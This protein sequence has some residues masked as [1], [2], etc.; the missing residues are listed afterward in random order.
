M[1]D[2]LLSL[3]HDLIQPFHRHHSKIF[4]AMG[5]QTGRPAPRKLPDRKLCVLVVPN[6]NSAYGCMIC[7]EVK[8]GD[9]IL[10]I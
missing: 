3:K 6:L 7:C 5:H 8:Q 9:D 1:F 4:P 10:I 2:P